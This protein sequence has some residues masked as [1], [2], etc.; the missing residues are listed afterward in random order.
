MLSVRVELT[1][2]YMIS[3]TDE[4]KMARRSQRGID[5]HQQEQTA[6]EKML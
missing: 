6:F 2:Y 3:S 1:Y 5:F 4:R